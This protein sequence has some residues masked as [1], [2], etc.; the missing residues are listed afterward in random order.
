MHALG[1]RDLGVALDFIAMIGEAS[2]LDDFAARVAFGLDQVIACGSA[3]YNEVN[4]PRQRVRWVTGV[5][6]RPADVEAF[7]R[8]MPENPFI[9]HFARQPDSD[10]VS[11]AD[12]LSERRWRDLGVYSDLYHPHRLEHILAVNAAKMPVQIGI[13]LFRDR[14]P[15]SERDRAMLSMLRPHLAN[16]YRNVAMLDDLGQRVA[17]LDRAIEIGGL[18][19]I[20]LGV[21]DRVREMTTTARHWLVAYFGAPSVDDRLPERVRDW[22]H[23]ASL[24]ASA[25]ELLPPAAA[26]TLVMGRDGARLILRLVHHGSRRLLLMHEQRVTPRAEHLAALGLARREAEILTWVAAG[27]SDAEIAEI[28]AISPR[29]VSHTLERVYRKLGVET[30]TAAVMRVLAAAALK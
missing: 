5:P 9:L 2:D 27:K 8:H 18:G 3:A 26:T 21:D 30:R 17:L 1:R 4:V 13:S 6:A 19:A 15:F 11:N 16:V 14:T 28:L 10:A 23:R 24:P 22:L 25:A 20:L 12:L 7:E 29:T